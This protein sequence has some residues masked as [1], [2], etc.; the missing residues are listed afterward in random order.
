MCKTLAKVRANLLFLG[1]TAE[2]LTGS[3]CIKNTKMATILMENDFKVE[4]GILK[5]N[6]DDDEEQNK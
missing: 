5:D 2:W 1:V 6:D 4:N 3:I